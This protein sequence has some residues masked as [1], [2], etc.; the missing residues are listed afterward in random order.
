MKSKID[1]ALALVTAL[2]DEEIIRKMASCLPEKG[3]NIVLS[4][5][6]AC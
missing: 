4:G 1:K 3:S 2:E 5:R 6:F